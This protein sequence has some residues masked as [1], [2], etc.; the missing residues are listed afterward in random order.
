MRTPPPEVL[1]VMRK[2]RVEPG[3]G[4]GFAEALLPA[5]RD[6][7]QLTNNTDMG[8]DGWLVPGGSGPT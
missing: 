1:H 6:I 3:D 8:G 4:V 5:G 2:L 7:G